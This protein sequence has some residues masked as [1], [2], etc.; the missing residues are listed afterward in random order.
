MITHIK[1]IPFSLRNNKLIG[2]ASIYLFGNL[3]QKALGFLLIP[4]YTRFLTPSDYGMTGIAISVGSVVTIAFGLGIPGSIARLYYEY[5][6]SEERIKEFISSHFL[7]LAGSIAILVALLSFFGG[8]V[9]DRWLGSQIPFSP[10]I[11][12]VLWTSYA[13]ILIQV[14]LSMYR[15]QQKSKQFIIAQVANFLL[16]VLLAILFVGILKQGAKG[17]LIGSL[18]GSATIALWLTG[19]VARQ[20]GFRFFNPRMIWESLI[21]GAPLVLHSLSGWIMNF[22]DRLLL[23]TRISL[24]EI[25][26][27]TLGYQMGMI[28]SV[29]VTSINLAYTPFY[30]ELFKKEQNPNSTITIICNIY[31]AVIGS[32]C[33]VM[34]LFVNEI[35]GLVAPPHYEKAVIYAP[36]VLL[37]YLFNG[38]YY[39]LSV[40]LFYH[41]KTHIIPIITISSAILNILLN[42]WWIPIWGPMGSAWATLVVFVLSAVLAYFLGRKYQELKIN[43]LDVLIANFFLLAAVFL[44]NTTGILAVYRNLIKPL[45][46]IVFIV[47]AYARFLRPILS[48]TTVPLKG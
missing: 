14:P 43:Y 42:L 20:S 32:I 21:Y 29:L 1:Q 34:V 36:I 45:L 40:P 27:Y 33:L 10:Y 47:F 6:D 11:Q 15:A 19:A 5:N 39:M 24:A 46:L 17:Q 2:N 13:D 7:F 28:M 18:C 48:S 22:A 23:E 37:S 26:Y 38:Y 30:F 4:L 41:K 9:W 3:I 31:L 8:W 16:S 44:T 35:I 12:I 25:G